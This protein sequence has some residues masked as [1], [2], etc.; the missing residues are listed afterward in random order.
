MSLL[1]RLRARFWPPSLRLQ[2]LV[3]LLAGLVVSQA[4]SLMFF[5]DERRLA[6]RAALVSEAVSRVASV[7]RLLE[8]SDPSL[9][10]S[11]I[12]AASTPVTR[13]VVASQSALDDD[14]PEWQ[15]RR[16]SQALLEQLGDE[17]EVRVALVETGRRYW[18]PRGHDRD[19]DEGWE[20]DKPWRGRD[21]IMDEEGGR[22]GGHRHP[23]RAVVSLVISTQLAD[24][25][26][27]N[28]DVSFR[29][30]P[31]QWAWP[32]VLS[33]ALTALAIIAVVTLTLGR[34]TRS[35]KAL[36]AA[37]QR[38]SRGARPELL[39]SRGPR[40]VRQAT[41]AFNAMQEKL[42]RFVADRTRLL[43]SISHD[44]RTP[45]TAMR[46]RVELLE[47][48]ETRRKLIEMLEEMQRMAE[49]TLAFAKEEAAEEPPRKLDLAALVESLAEDFADMGADVT[50]LPAERSVYECRPVALKRAIRNLVENAVRYGERARIG[51][52]R[53]AG[54]LV[55]SVEDD[56]P[57]LP[58]EKIEEVFEPFV[59]VET[60][61]SR[62]TG[63]VGLGLSIARSI[64]RA[65]GGEL[66]LTNRPEGGLRA[67]IR[68]PEA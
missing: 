37:A 35:L 28:T 48:S 57:G 54:A 21:S 50:A 56:G 44:L 47:D 5:F 27:L 42:S 3:L 51:L 65:H 55:V 30:P 6:I 52:T 43:A 9:E 58:P 11:I 68:L 20:R 64:V 4:V 34:M 62:E 45:I 59:R 17:R 16:L 66:T 2:L 39:E 22:F 41:A 19:D 60:S 46:L 8:A 63:G 29:R 53:E 26:W 18:P 13:F 40:E 32:S 25:R 23:P 14:S 1:A 33:M 49:A 67:E 31:L 7:A 38:F 61:R 36:A 24:G 10:P 15:T 12:M